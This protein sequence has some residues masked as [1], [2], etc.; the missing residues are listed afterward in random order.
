MEKKIQAR[1]NR[2]GWGS[3]SPPHLRFSLTSI[4]DELKKIVLEWKI[5][6]SYK[7]S[8]S[9]IKFIDIYNIIIDLNTRDVILSVM[10][11]KGFSYF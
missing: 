1:K 9:S 4:F 7:T 2:G 3:C 5:V 8:W 11:S 10:N 6:Q